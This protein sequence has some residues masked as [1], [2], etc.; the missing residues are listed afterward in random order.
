MSQL[1]G[2]DPKTLPFLKVDRILSRLEGQYETYKG[3]MR[4]TI[5]KA[6]GILYFEYRNKY[7]EEV[8][9]LT[10]ERLEEDRATFYVIAGGV[11]TTLEFKT[12]G[13]KVELIGDRA[14]FVKKAKA[15]QI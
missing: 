15:E 4:I 14:K 8:V 3:T 2:Q 6:G 9:P 7:Q 11:K 1:I 13:D 12:S 5:K 10:P